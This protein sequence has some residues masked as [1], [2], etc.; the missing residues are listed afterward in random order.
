MNTQLNALIDWVQTTRQ[1]NVWLDYEADALLRRLQQW[2]LARY[3]GGAAMQAE[4]ACVLHST[5][6]APFSSQLAE[7]LTNDPQRIAI[8]L[9]GAKLDYGSHILPCLSETSLAVRFTDRPQISHGP[10]VLTL[11]LL[12]A[13]DKARRLMALHGVAVRED[14][15]RQCLTQLE[16]RKLSSPAGIIDSMAFLSIIDGWAQCVSSSHS[17]SP[18]LV[19]QA[20]EL[21]P[22][23]N[24][25]DFSKMMALFWDATSSAS[26]Q[27]QQ[28]LH[29]QTLLEHA[30]QVIAPART[31]ITS[32]VISHLAAPQSINERPPSQMEDI[33]VC[34]LI[35]GIPLPA[36]SVQRQTLFDACREITLSVSPSDARRSTRDIVILPDDPVC[37]IDLPYALNN[38]ATSSQQQEKCFSLIQ[39]HLDYLS[40]NEGFTQQAAEALLRALQEQSDRHGE[41]LDGLAINERTLEGL[42]EISASTREPSVLPF[43]IDLLDETPAAESVSAENSFAARAYRCWINHIREK[44][45]DVALAER[46][47]L[48]PEELQSVCQILILTSYKIDL[49]GQL[50]NTLEGFEGHPAASICCAA[51]ILNEFTTWLGYDH[52]AAQERPQSKIN[53]GTTLFS[54]PISVTHN[55][56][57]PGLGTAVH[58]NI[59]WLGDWLIAL[60]N[61]AITVVGGDGLTAEQRRELDKISPHFSPLLRTSA[62]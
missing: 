53:P 56:P 13:S 26:T 43:A 38:D 4:P 54:P 8:M 58:S 16:K 28:H 32:C 37:K 20:G 14:A 7:L 27:W 21:V 46:S 24:Q 39:S 33:P 30:P 47:G 12:S 1:H 31:I 22:F 52:I 3:Y 49:R 45:F 55:T 6:P 10:Y 2:K 62:R 23:L 11:T 19:L 29:I 40:Q 59:V 18:A 50:E 41:L 42:D 15:F 35:E 51:R 34:P 9:D 17:L 5:T 48:A 44:G 36:V 25:E 60:L 57:L 61:R